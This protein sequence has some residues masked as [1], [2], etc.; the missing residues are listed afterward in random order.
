VTV[1]VQIPY[2]SVRWLPANW[3]FGSNANLT[4]STV[5]R[6]ETVQ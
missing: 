6:R 4:A 1:T 3:F 5:M 2:S